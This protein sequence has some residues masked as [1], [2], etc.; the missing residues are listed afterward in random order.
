MPPPPQYELDGGSRFRNV[1]FA[2]ISDREKNILRHLTGKLTSL[3][4]T[5]IYLLSDEELTRHVVYELSRLPYDEFCRFLATEISPFLLIVDRAILSQIYRKVEAKPKEEEQ[6]TLDGI[7]VLIVAS[8]SIFVV[9]TRLVRNF[10][11]WLNTRLQYF[12]GDFVVTT[13]ALQPGGLITS[14]RPIVFSKYSIPQEGVQGFKDIL[15]LRKA[16]TVFRQERL[17]PSS[18]PIFSSKYSRGAFVQGL[19]GIRY[20][21]KAKTVFRQKVEQHQEGTYRVVV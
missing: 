1:K 13:I 11:Q 5:Q 9:T 17:I 8:V 3:S 7:V 12:K 6:I 21:R 18:R 2:P 19:K 20:H 15:Y 16:K 14:N 10:C 4:E